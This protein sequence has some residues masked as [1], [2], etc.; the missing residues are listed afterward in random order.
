VG[1]AGADEDGDSD[2][3]DADMMD[4]DLT[5]GDSSASSAEYWQGLLKEHWK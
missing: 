1:N 3:G 4:D 2:D 5:H